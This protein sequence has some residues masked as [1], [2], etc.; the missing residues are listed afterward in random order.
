MTVNIGFSRPQLQMFADLRLTYVSQPQL[1]E[2]AKEKKIYVDTN[3]GVFADLAFVGAHDIP[4]DL[5]AMI[6][7]LYREKE[8]PLTTG[9]RVMVVK[10]DN[11]V[12]L[13][14]TDSK[15]LGKIKL[16]PGDLVYTGQFGF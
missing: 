16:D 5:G 12:V 15:A 4:D 14:I 10:R 7:R 8:R 1:N 11:M 2:I 3:W 13:T 9:L 6:Y